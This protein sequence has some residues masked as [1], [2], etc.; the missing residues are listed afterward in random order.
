MYPG[1]PMAWA[2]QCRGTAP[3]P[4]QAAGSWP[5]TAT[6]RART[7]SVWGMMPTRCPPSTTMGM[8]WCPPAAAGLPGRRG[9]RPAPE[10]QVL[11]TIDASAAEQK[12]RSLL[13]GWEKVGTMLETTYRNPSN[14]CTWPRKH[15]L[16]C[17]YTAL[18]AVYFTPVFAMDGPKTSLTEH[19]R[20]PMKDT[21]SQR[22]YG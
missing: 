16:Y 8:W 2:Q 11:A 5:C 7:R 18:N 9:S 6:A 3:E 17:M 10:A 19:A 4:L 21:S 12:W 20:E 15:A 1:L 14:R 22:R 13:P